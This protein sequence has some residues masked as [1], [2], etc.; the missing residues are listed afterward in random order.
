MIVKNAIENQLMPM[1]IIL[2]RDQRTTSHRVHDQASPVMRV[3]ALISKSAISSL[4]QTK[5]Q[6]IVARRHCI[7][8]ITAKTLKREKK[9]DSHL[10]PTFYHDRRTQHSNESFSVLRF[11]RLGCALVIILATLSVRSAP[12]MN[13]P[14]KTDDMKWVNPCGVSTK[15]RTN[16]SNPDIAQL[17]DHDL[18]NQI[19]L[20]A[21]TALKHAQL[22]RDEFYVKESDKISE[23]KDSNKS[24]SE[25]APSPPRMD[26]CTPHWHT[27]CILKPRPDIQPASIRQTFKTDFA[28]VHNLWRKYHYAWLPTRSEIPKELGEELDKEHL[29]KLDI[30]TSLVDAYEYM[31]KYAVGLEQVVLDQKD[32]QPKYHQKFTEAEWK[33]RAVLCEIQVA[34]EER[35]VTRRPD[36][37]RDVMTSDFRTMTDMTSRDLRDWLIFREYMNGLEYV[38]QVFS[39]LRLRL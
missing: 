36:V 29:N 1:E 11:L 2:I 5:Y 12:I 16:G 24:E 21:R 30:N 3:N 22:F 23:A 35:S 13:S 15:L 27:A 10:M 31:Q 9:S 4:K 8:A 19:V 32:Y 7:K 28:S 26:T 37:T 14:N 34:I 25:A 39:H 33:L 6:G 38:I 20:Q 17:E 18:L